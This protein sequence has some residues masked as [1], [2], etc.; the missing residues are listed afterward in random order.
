MDGYISNDDFY[1]QTL[2]ITIK[3]LESSE[4]QGL[5][6]VLLHIKV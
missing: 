3:E 4:L 1:M 2:S 5:A 6:T